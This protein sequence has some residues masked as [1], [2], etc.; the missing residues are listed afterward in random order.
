MSSYGWRP[1]H[2]YIETKYS[3]AL[4]FQ[5]HRF[6][7]NQHPVAEV[8]PVLLRSGQ[9]ASREEAVEKR[10]LGEQGGTPSESSWNF[11]VFGDGDEAGVKIKFKLDGVKSFQSNLDKLKAFGEQDDVIS[12]CSGSTCASVASA[13]SIELDFQCHRFELNQHS[14]A[15]VMP[16]LLKSGQ[17][18]SREKAV[19]KRNARKEE[20]LQ[21]PPGTLLSLAFISIAIS[22]ILSMISVTNF[23]FE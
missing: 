8:M 1:S 18:A 14:V 5:C 21:S 3:F 7:V 22:S 4:A 2:R 13:K 9:S 19:E 23:M 15:E 20:L 6:K 11:I 16:V 10:N 12:G 17:S